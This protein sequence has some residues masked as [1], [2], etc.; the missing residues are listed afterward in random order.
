MRSIHMQPSECSWALSSGKR[1]RQ[2]LQRLLKSRSM[3][4]C[5]DN[6]KIWEN[7][8]SWLSILRIAE[9]HYKWTDRSHIIWQISIITMVMV[10]SCPLK[11]CLYEDCLLWKLKRSDYHYSS[12]CCLCCQSHHSVQYLSSWNFPQSLC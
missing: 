9:N 8:A 2:F 4:V 10:S 3:C 6:L 11:W 12:P 5:R 7:L 1:R